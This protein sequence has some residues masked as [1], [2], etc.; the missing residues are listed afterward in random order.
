MLHIRLIYR[1]LQPLDSKRKRVRTELSF[2]LII[3]AKQWVILTTPGED[4]VKVSSAN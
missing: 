4:D 3:F 2:F 1:L